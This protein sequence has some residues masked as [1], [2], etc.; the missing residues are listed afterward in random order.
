MNPSLSILQKLKKLF[1]QSVANITD[2]HIA[3]APFAFTL[4]NEDFYFL[5]N[6]TLTGSET[7][8]YYKE[9]S[10]FAHIANSVVK[11]PFTWA[12]DSEN[13]LYNLYKKVLEEAATIDPNYFTSE[14][15]IKLDKAK[16]ILFNPE[17]DTYSEKY[18]KYKE[19][20]ESYFV[21]EQKLYD[22]VV[23]KNDL[24]TN[25]ELTKWQ[26]SYDNLQNEKISLLVDWQV[27]GGKST[28]DS[29][30][31][32][33]NSIYFSKTNFIQNWNDTKNNKLSSPNLLTDDDGVDFLSTSCI[34]NG[35]YQYQAPIW[36]KI[37]LS[38]Q[39]II[40]LSDDFARS[41]PGITAEF[42]DNETKLDNITFEYC[43]IDILRPWF[44]ESILNNNFW[45]YRNEAKMLSHGD[46]SMTGE[47]P[48]YPIKL[49]LAKNIELTF[50]P[51]V[52]QNMDLQDKLKNG[53]RV[54]FGPLLLKT[55]PKNL[56]N[57]KVITFK[58]QQLSTN[59]LSLLS[60]IGV[61]N[62]ISNPH[63]NESS[64]Y[65]ILET[66]NRHPQLSLRANVEMKSFSRRLTSTS[67]VPAT[68]IRPANS[69][70][71]IPF[72][73]RAIKPM[74]QPI[75]QLANTCNIC[76][77]VIDEHNQAIEVAEIQIMNIENACTQS[78]LSLP[79]GTYNFNDIDNGT[80]QFTVKKTG[81]VTIEKRAEIKGNT[82]LDFLLN[83]QPVPIESFQVMGV[84]CKI[85]PK[86]PNPIEGANY[87]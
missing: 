23:S 35:I 66:M 8:K 80:Y 82:N 70:N 34:P 19:F 65:K 26:L 45:K 21:L 62:T 49:I 69:P 75:M 37:S 79:N 48:A 64:K 76:G 56:E 14:E 51:S 1:L 29:A 20:S 67:A 33:Y 10:E 38:K 74:V 78:F 32:T 87:L 43:F 85:M 28:I 71:R 2:Y 55:I 44:D 68:P 61:Q 13:L 73:S 52:P 58:V 60:N 86:L 41:A 4:T 39:E 11:K 30:L 54:F 53:M 47:I 57:D 84:I 7:K 42:G 3:F 12:I 59:Q 31:A 63:F 83:I 9:K 18:K 24:S 25:S 46:E 27:I 77:K 81:Y 50:T 72:R 40:S 15:Q 17:D 5:K 16:A 36:K 6:E 22:L